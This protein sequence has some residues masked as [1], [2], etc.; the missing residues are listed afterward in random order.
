MTQFS[1]LYGR[2]LDQELGTDD[3]T[4]L[5]LTARRQAAVNDGIREFADLTECLVKQSTITVTGG[6]QEYAL[7]TLT[8]FLRVA[9]QNVEF[10]YVDASSNLTVL[11]GDD[12]PRRDIEWLNRY[13]P[14]WRESSV[15]SSVQQL[16]TFHYVRTNGSTL[17]LGLVPTPCT[18]S[19]AS[20][21]V[22]FPYVQ[23]PALLTS[24]TSE[25]FGGRSDLQPYHIAAVHYA[26]H[27]LEKLRRDREA[28]DYQFSKFLGYVE[29]FIAKLRP[30]GGTHITTARLYFRSKRPSD[31]AKDPRT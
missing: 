12:L 25:P 5:F 3:S 2:L 31:E 13:E 30:K 4:V 26:A 16:P 20:A 21:S 19:S 7:S 11:A 10:Q 9:K 15:T 23:Y 27:Q 8:D 6:T 29:R 1:S 18:G 28:S 24:D 14:G 17:M 22:V